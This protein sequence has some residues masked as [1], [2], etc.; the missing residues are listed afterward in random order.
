M[1]DEV[2][3]TL[4]VCSKMKINIIELFFSKTVLFIDFQHVF[5]RVLLLHRLNHLEY[6]P[7]S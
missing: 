7:K 5:F 2:I 3:E 6:Q 4:T 1:V